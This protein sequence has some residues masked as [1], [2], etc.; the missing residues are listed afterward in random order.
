[1]DMRSIDLNLL[2]SLDVLLTER[3]VTRAARRLHL[4]QPALSAQLARL[5]AVFD[6]PLLLPSRSGRGMIP[7]VRASE[8]VQPLR[9]V[10]MDLDTLVKVKP[11]FDPAVS[12]R[13]FV[14]AAT[15]YGGIAVGLPLFAGAQDVGPG[16][17]F[18]IRSFDPGRILEQV[19][20]GEVDVV[21]APTFMM[22][23]SLVSK[24]LFEEELMMAQ[25]K[26][27]SRG[28][29]PIDLDTYCE[30]DH[31]LVSPSGGAFFGSVDEILQGLGRSRR[32]AVSVQNFLLAPAILNHTD[33][34]STLPMRLIARCPSNLDVFPLP[35]PTRA[36]QF[37]VAWHPRNRDDPAMMW[38]SQR[39]TAAEISGLPDCR[40]PGKSSPG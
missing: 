22:P 19:E 32:I 25:R 15:D 27:H 29:G 7:T 8:L 21:I 35:F 20:N 30:L 11:G 28:N 26:G 14:I 33:Y 2:V 24:P 12:E 13:R 1:M 16:I 5:R 36:L 38:L 9:S 10:L 23:S 37:C 40:Q 4:S 18:A 6:D 3:N 17:Q 34:V 39:I 31:V